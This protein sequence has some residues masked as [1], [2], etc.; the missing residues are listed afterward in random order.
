MLLCIGI[1]L[2]YPFKEHVLTAS[3]KDTHTGRAQTDFHLRESLYCQDAM[4]IGDQSQLLGLYCTPGAQQPDLASIR[5]RPGLSCRA[6]LAPRYAEHS[7]L[8]RWE[9]NTLLRELH[10]WQCWEPLNGV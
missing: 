8:P 6:V 1:S 4:S 10:L 3:I 9:S 5:F 2:A 7:S